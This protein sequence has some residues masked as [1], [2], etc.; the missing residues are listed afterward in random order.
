MNVVVFRTDRIGDLVLT[1]P[2]AEAIKRRHPSARVTFVVQRYTRELALRAP[3]IDQVLDIPER[4]TDDVAALA[5]LLAPHAF[6]AAVFAYPR[7][8]LARAARRARIP[9]RIGSAYRWY[10]PLFTDRIREHRHDAT[11]HE[12]AYNIRLLAPLDVDVE[13]VPLPQLR[14]S[15]EDARAAGEAL[16]AAGIEE[17]RPFI[18][19]HPGSGGSA[20]DWSAARFGA[21]ARMLLAHDPALAVLV[22]GTDAERALMDVV[23]REAGDR[24]F[25]SA[26]DLQLPVLSAVLSKT[27][28]FC[29][30]ST[31]PLHIAA[32]H[33]V[34]SLGFYPFLTACHPRRW[35]PLGPHSRVLTPEPA[36][37][38]EACARGR[39]PRH[40]DMSRISVERAV[41]AAQVLYAST[42]GREPAEA[43]AGR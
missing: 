19:M 40:D 26:A 1:L 7:P 42:Q 2:V 21:L 13:H 20:K 4:D 28:L 15:D 37:D 34:P 18:T 6:T 11:R 32:A 24:A 5:G 3:H 14:V 17:G 33:G 41:D 38:C 23:R 31:G 22:T 43:S 12:S 25:L 8:G 10:A 35:G 39:C 29:S 9:M 16:R 30:N 27:S 36:A